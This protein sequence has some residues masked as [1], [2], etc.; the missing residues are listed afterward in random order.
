MEE[1]WLDYYAEVKAYY[2]SI[3]EAVARAK[4]A[5]RRVYLQDVAPEKLKKLVQ[6]EVVIAPL[7]PP[8][9]ARR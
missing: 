4:A 6:A 7:S 2:E 3:D 8:L 1:A 5:G 9:R